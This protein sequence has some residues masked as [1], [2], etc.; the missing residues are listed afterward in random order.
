[1]LHADTFLGDG[2]AADDP[3]EVRGLG[4]HSVLDPVTAREQA[5]ALVGAGSGSGGGSGAVNVF[6]VDPAGALHR[7]VRLPKAPVGGWTRRL[8]TEAV[9]AR[10]GSG[11][12]LSCG[13]YAPTVAIAGQV[14]ARNPRCAG[15]DCPRKSAGCDLDH[16]T[17]W[18]RGPT[19]VTNLAP[20]CRRHHEHKTR[21][22]VHTQ[23]HSDGSVDT[24]MLTG[25]VITTRPEP[26]P[27][28]APG[29][30]H[31]HRGTDSAA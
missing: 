8:L 3:A 22:L 25:L 11:P 21:G 30:G 5:H 13:T 4:G 9:A 27:G 12:P 31:D 28:H 7:V 26:L 15:Y 6:L 29:E 18:P 2:P 10:L 23:L 16:D 17:P 1:V 24:L 19:Q 20:R 14:R